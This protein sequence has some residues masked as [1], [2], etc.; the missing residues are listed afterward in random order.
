MK[1]FLLILNLSIAFIVML[2]SCGGKKTSPEE[3][4][5]NYGKYFVEKLNANQVD[6]LTASYPDIA[7]ADS[8]MPISSDTIIVAE[9]APGQFVVTLAEGITLKVNRSEDGN[10]TVAESKGLFAFPADKV[11][12]AKK[13]GMWD[14]N[15]SDARLNERMKDEEFPKYLKKIKTVK[16]KDIISIGRLKEPKELYGIMDTTQP[17]TNLTDKAIDGKDYSVVV[18]YEWSYPAFD[19]D[20]DGFEKGKEVKSGKNIP[21]KGSVNYAM[22]IGFRGYSKIVA[23]KWK[24]TPEQLQEKFA[25][26]TGKEYQEYLDSKK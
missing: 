7:K 13:T 19:W 14:D 6:S 8:I 5:R 12:V 9:N 24:L 3:E 17:L 21:P 11:D 20:D 4:V 16:T 18:E 22:E 1:K 25:S 2:C 26:Y 10:I 23:I 15:L